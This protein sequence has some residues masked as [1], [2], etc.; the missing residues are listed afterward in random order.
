MSRRSAARVDARGVGSKYPGR[1]VNA[2]PVDFARDVGLVEPARGPLGGLLPSNSGGEGWGR[3]REHVTTP[4]GCTFDTHP[5]TKCLSI[6]RIRIDVEEP[7]GL[8]SLRPLSDILHPWAMKV[9]SCRANNPALG[10]MLPG[11]MPPR[12]QVINMGQQN[13]CRTPLRQFQQQK[14]QREWYAVRLFSSSH[15]NR[16]EDGMQSTLASPRGPSEPDRVDPCGWLQ[17]PIH[18]G[19]PSAECTFRGSPLTTAPSLSENGVWCPCTRPTEA[20]A[21]GEGLRPSS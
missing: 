20:G 1:Q 4:P 17:R 9:Q 3:W 19:S 16:I 11:T 2:G 21:G 7:G 6:S 13:W 5:R 18:L 10:A 15:L 12:L 8:F 14:Q